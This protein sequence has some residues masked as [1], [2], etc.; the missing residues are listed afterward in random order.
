MAVVN[1]TG[2]E[3]GVHW[4]SARSDGDVY[5]LWTESNTGVEADDTRGRG[6]VVPG[7]KRRVSRSNG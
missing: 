5:L 6:H 3:L 4:A 7:G 1:V 2:W